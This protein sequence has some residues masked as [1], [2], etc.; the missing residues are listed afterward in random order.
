MADRPDERPPLWVGHVL[1]RS[2]VLEKSND[3]MMRLGLRPID[4]GDDYAILELRGGTHLAIFRGEEPSSGVADF[5]FM[6]EDLD[7]THARFTEMGLSPSPIETG[8]IHRSFNVRDPSG[9]E[10][11]FNSS[12]VSDLPV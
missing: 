7:A 9:L 6:V 11:P 12:H 1:M 10:I 4:K 5:D 3:F 8:R 2:H